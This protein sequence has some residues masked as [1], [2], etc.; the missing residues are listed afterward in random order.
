[1]SFHLSNREWIAS[2]LADEIYGPERFPGW[3]ND[4]YSKPEEI[5]PSIMMEFS[6]AM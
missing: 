2:A 6:K 5:E 4:L 3:K 1:M